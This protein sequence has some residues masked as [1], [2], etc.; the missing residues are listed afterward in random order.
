MMGTRTVSPCLSTCSFFF[1][2]SCSIEFFSQY[3]ALQPSLS[4]YTE[5]L[6]IQLVRTVSAY[7]V[8]CYEILPAETSQLSGLT[9]D[10]WT[11]YR[12]IAAFTD[13][14]LAAVD[15]RIRRQSH[16][17]LLKDI[18]KELTMLL[19]CCVSIYVSRLHVV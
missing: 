6:C 16:N 1:H 2:C 12:Y 14:S 19:F 11:T 17:T 9:E 10:I 8:F 5:Y 4:R 15:S 18:A 7:S 3:Q 13:E